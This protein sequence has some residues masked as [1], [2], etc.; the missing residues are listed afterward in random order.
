[1][2]KGHRIAQSGLTG[3]DDAAFVDAQFFIIGLVLAQPAGQK[4]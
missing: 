1:M 2:K 4:E 3:G